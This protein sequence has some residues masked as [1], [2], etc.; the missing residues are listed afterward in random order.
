[1]AR[2]SRHR[3]PEHL[4]WARRINRA[5]G[6]GLSDGGGLRG[7][8]LA[9]PLVTTSLIEPFVTRLEHIGV[10]Y[11][12][13]GSMAAIAYGEP[14]MTHDL[15]VVVALTLRDL[16]RFVD[17]F[18]NNEF[19]CPPEEL[20]AVEIRRAQRG[21]VNLIHR[22]SAFRADVYLACDELHRWALSRRQRISLGAF[23][24]AIA[25]VEYVIVRKLEY[26]RTGADDVAKHLRDIRGML[27]V[28][29]KQIDRAL[30]APWIARLGLDAEWQRF[31]I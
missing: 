15:D 17:A 26:L 28:S 25:P 30:L 5:A 27:E 18:P 12:V 10:P 20:I 9:A 22:P 16:A 4:G 1:M 14:R 29:A 8:G 6:I 11:C 19:Y 2:G 3:A 23:E 21:R 7:I 24:V 13:T 31:V